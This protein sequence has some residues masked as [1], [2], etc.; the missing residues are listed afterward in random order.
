MTDEKYE[1]LKVI[2]KGL[3]ESLDTLNKFFPYEKDPVLGAAMNN[4]DYRVD[5]IYDGIVS[6]IDKIDSVTTTNNLSGM[7]VE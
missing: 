5:S 2:R 7:G 3:S 6:L 4:R 1:K